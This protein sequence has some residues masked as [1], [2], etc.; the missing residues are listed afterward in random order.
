[1][2]ESIVKEEIIKEIPRA[3]H[4]YK[5]KCKEYLTRL[6]PNH[7]WDFNVG[8]SKAWGLVYHALLWRYFPA[9]NTLLKEMRFLNYKFLDSDRLYYL[10]R[11]HSI[12]SKK[13]HSKFI[14]VD[15]YFVS[16]KIYNK[17]EM[18]WYHKY[19][20]PYIK[21]KILNPLGMYGLKDWKPNYLGFKQSLF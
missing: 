8:D 18:F 3:K 21:T 13:L 10:D 14:D 12:F 5:T 15:K 17:Q 6:G 16:N 20:N 7:V 11:N 9:E 19:L 4:F 1:M 2:I